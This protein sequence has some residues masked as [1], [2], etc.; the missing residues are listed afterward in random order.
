MNQDSLYNNRV[1]I[2]R[3]FWIVLA[4]VVVWA[5]ADYVSHIGKVALVVS[6]V[7]RDAIVMVGSDKVGNGTRWVKAGDYKVSVSKDGFIKQQET[8]TVSEQK[9]QNVL[10][11][12]LIPDS[13][14]AKKWAND[15]SDDYKNNEQYG[16]IEA[17]NNGDYFSQTN[18]IT[19]QLPYTDPYFKI[20]YVTDNNQ[21]IKLTIETPSPRYRFYA[22]EKIRQLGYDPTDFVIEFKDFKNPLEQQ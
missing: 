4:I 13:D 22:V 9:K 21:S 10:A 11:I 17:K 16:S 12:S 14:A 19:T 8:L 1:K 3:G 6:V 2:V 15:H 18:P 7:P 5:V 20:G